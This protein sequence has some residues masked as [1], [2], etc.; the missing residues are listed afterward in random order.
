MVLLNKSGLWK[1][2]SHQLIS[3]PEPSAFSYQEPFTA[4]SKQKQQSTSAIRLG[5]SM[6]DIW[7]YLFTRGQVS[8]KLLDIVS[9]RS[10]RLLGLL[11]VK[12]R[13]PL[14]HNQV[15]DPPEWK[16]KQPNLHTRLLL[17]RSCRRF[18]CL[19]QHGC[20]GLCVSVCFLTARTLSAYL[21]AKARLWLQRNTELF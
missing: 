4:E 8:N 1:E 2:R 14:L 10:F 9:V 16:P 21:G 11:K 6:S 3:T 20:S 15:C 12:S 13:K 17:S 18:V 19:L 7:K 5:S